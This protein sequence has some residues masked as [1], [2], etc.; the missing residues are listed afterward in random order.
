M[1]SIEDFQEVAN[2]LAKD[3][4]C[5]LID[6]P[7]HG[8]T[9]VSCDADYQMPQVALGIVELLGALK[10]ERCF[11]VGYSMGGRLAL[12]LTLNFPQHF[13]KV[14]L[15]SASPGLKTKEER[16]NR[17]L[18]D[19]K[20]IDRLKILDFAAFLDRWYQNPLFASFRQHPNYQKAIANK[21]NNNPSKLA[22]SLRYMGLGAQPSL[23]EK[24]QNNSIPLLLIVG[25]G[26]RKF[27]AINQKMADAVPNADLKIVENTDHNVHFEHPTIFVRFLSVF[28]KT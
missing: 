2:K 21:L 9:R 6:L 28:F 14:V 24:L 1:G 27:I 22:K 15:E 17:V 23:W 12:Y 13:I 3:F 16:E 5:L 10:I 7:G 26:D 20:L 4:C 19:S 25:S 11:L 18:Q 8:K